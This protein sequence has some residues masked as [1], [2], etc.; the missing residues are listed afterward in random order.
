MVEGEVERRSIANSMLEG[1]FDGEFH[2]GRRCRVAV[3]A[4]SMLQGEDVDG[5][6]LGGGQ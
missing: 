1:E 3:N 5:W 6:G 4:N 2:V